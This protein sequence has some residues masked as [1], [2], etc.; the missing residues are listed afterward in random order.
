MKARREFI[1]KCSLGLA[2]SLIP[3]LPL[4][5]VNSSDFEG[6]VVND[7]EGEAFQLRDGRAIVKIKISKQQGSQS[8]SFLASSLPPG[9]VIPIHKHLNEDEFFF[10]H[11]GSGIFTLGEKQYPIKEGAVIIVPKGTWHGL[12][13][14]GDENIEL[15]F[16]YTPA[17]SEGYFR[18][19]GTPV[20]QPFVQ[21]TLDKR[22][23]IGK[24]WSVV[25][26]E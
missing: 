21:K 15:R 25:F 24:K 10:V 13:N 26:K 16:G 12:Q 14:T 19:V 18:E 4:N 5:A 23:A 11:K 6:L 2:S 22:K 8:I 7:N 9:D 20:G 3:P 1:Q 17:G